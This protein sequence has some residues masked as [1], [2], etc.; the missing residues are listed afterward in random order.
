MPGGPARLN[1]DPVIRL[2]AV[3]LGLA[4]GSRARASHCPQVAGGSGS[5]RRERPEGSRAPKQQPSSGGAAGGHAP[6]HRP[7]DRVRLEMHF[8]EAGKQ[9]FVCRNRHEVDMGSAA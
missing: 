9:R 3:G 8:P 4:G 1:E 7:R 5:L 2:R 6:R